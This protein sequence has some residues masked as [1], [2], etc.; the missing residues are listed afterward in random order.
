MLSLCCANQLD[1]KNLIDLELVKFELKDS[2]MICD[3]SVMICLYF[4]RWIV[5]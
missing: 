1:V 2:V 5:S 3:E 4:V